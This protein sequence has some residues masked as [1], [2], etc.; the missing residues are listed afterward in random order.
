MSRSTFKVLFLRERQQGERRNCPYHGTH[1]NQWDCIA[2]Q[3]QAEHPENALGRKRQEQGG[4]G[5]QPHIGQYQG[6]N[7][8]A[9]PV[10]IR[11]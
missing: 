1:Y 9:L 5:N 2:V 3:L 7:H 10:Y 6:A 11:P 4:T 8:Q